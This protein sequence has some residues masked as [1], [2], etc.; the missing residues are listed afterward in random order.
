MSEKIVGFVAA[1]LTGYRSDGSVNLD[2]VPAYA[3]MLH[4]NGMAGVFVNG[5]TGEGM[6]LT[7]DERRALAEAWVEAAPAGLQVLIHVGHVCQREAQALAEHASGV[8]ADGI[9][10]IGPVFFRPDTVEALVD[11]CEQTAA[12]APDLS[13]Y[14]YHMP[15]MNHVDFL[16]HDFLE[17]ADGRIPTLTGIKYTHHDLEDYGRC[18]A[19]GGGKY[20][21]LFGR[22]EVLKDARRLGARGAVGS[23]YNILAPLYHRLI[24]AD[25]ESDWVEVDR[26]QAISVKAIDLLA[27]SGGFM[28]GMKRVLVGLGLELGGMKCP[29]KN[30]SEADGDALLTALTEAGV[31]TYLN[32]PAVS[33]V[34]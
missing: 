10:E 34:A 21:V 26:L 27:G 3:E 11:Y 29:Q 32:T 30:L 7:T 15:S 8:G 13:Y 25:E 28:S 14:Y 33:E 20:D 23:T 17:V 24:Q 2:V 22:D 6:S 16:M 18:V 4:A 9:G 31:M 12:A 19:F 1:P 5:T